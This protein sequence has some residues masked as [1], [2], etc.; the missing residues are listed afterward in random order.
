MTHDICPEAPRRAEGHITR[1]IHGERYRVS[2][3]GAG[4]VDA[5]LDEELRATERDFGVG[6]TVLVEF[7]AQA[8]AQARIVHRTWSGPDRRRQ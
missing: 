6:D 2:V 8:G 1:R 5:L 7:A 4:F 3:I